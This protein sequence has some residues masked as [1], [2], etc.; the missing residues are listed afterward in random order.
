MKA[1]TNKN[2]HINKQIG[3]RGYIHTVI[4]LQ[5]LFYFVYEMRL[6]FA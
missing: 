3:C 6:L 2:K 1:L 5:F 4:G